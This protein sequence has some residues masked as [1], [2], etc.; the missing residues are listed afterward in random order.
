VLALG[1]AIVVLGLAST[2]SRARNTAL[3]TAALIERVAD[4]R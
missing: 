2:G 3:R 1:L 4:P